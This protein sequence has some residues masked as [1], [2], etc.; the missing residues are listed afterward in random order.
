[1]YPPAPVGVALLGSRKAEYWAWGESTA[2]ENP[3]RALA[4]LIPTHSAV[5]CHNA[6]FD[7]GVLTEKLGLS[8]PARIDDTMVLA[9]LLD[10]YGELSLKPLAE[11]HL[12][13]PPEEQDAVRQWLIDNKI[14][15]KNAK[16]WGAFIC[17]V[18]SH[19]VAP[20]AIG[21]VRRTKKLF[22]FF[23]PL[24]KKA[25]MWEA[26]QREMNL[27]PMLLDNEARGIHI[28]IFK[29]KQETKR[30]ESSLYVTDTQIKKVLKASKLDID[31]NY[32][33]AQAIKRRYRIKL[34]LTDKGNERTSKDVVA[35]LKIPNQL[36]ALLLYRSS[37]AYSIRNFMRP[38]LS[39]GEIIHTHWNQ[40]RNHSDA[41]ARTGRLSSSPNFQNLTT[42]EKRADLLTYL[43]ALWP[44][45]KW[46]L[47]EIRSYIVAPKGW[48]L[49]GHDYNQQEFRL[50]A[51]FEDGELA[52]AYR[53]NPD[54]DMHK[55]AQQLVLEKSGLRVERK[56]IK[57]VGFAKIYGAGVPRLAATLGVPLDEAYTI[58]RAYEHALPGIYSRDRNDPGLQA[59]CLARG[60]SGKGIKTLGG[61]H[62]VAEAPRVV[63]GELRTYEYKLLNYLI[64]G[65]AADQTKEAMR[66]WWECISGRQS[67]VRFLLT[68]HDEL[69]GMAKTGRVKKESKL[70]G[71]CMTDAFHGQ[72]DVPVK[73]DAEFGQ[74][75]AGM[76]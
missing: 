10:P 25:G 60:R 27:M 63:N 56:P 3:L 43:H 35:G 17:K 30:F 74:N 20:Y 48:T 34:P 66:L 38:W 37:I 18:P 61:R 11:R 39:Q 8:M 75:W 57:T 31:S 71:Q 19:V 2:P 72:I 4:E 6:S 28:D 73:T 41:G 49:F 29:L 52:Q 15:R 36:K 16:N 32:D 9:F 23:V 24:I 76:K 54:T 58:V 50:L 65:S 67:E 42:G 47:P 53:Q 14:V 5:L 21:D 69:L 51:H 33:L 1:M 68:A 70:L 12:G 26:Y 40:V 22:Q 62:Y 59:Q 7:I 55:F 44:K 46:E 45:A 13:M 64:Q